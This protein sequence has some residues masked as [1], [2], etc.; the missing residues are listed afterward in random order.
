MKGIKLNFAAEGASLDLSAPVTGFD[1]SVQNG[2]VNFGTAA[3]TD[4]IF[5][6]RGTDLMKQAQAGQ[7][8]DD[9]GAMH[10]ANSTARCT[11]SSIRLRPSR[12]ENSLWT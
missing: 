4:H 12:R 6:D 1:T 3:G 11:I 5:P 10:A 7:M 2:L 8:L 9:R